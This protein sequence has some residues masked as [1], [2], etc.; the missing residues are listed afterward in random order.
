VDD[1]RGRVP[2]IGPKTLDRIRP[3]LTVTGA[4]RKA[5]LAR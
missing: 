5:A 3:F 4:P 1:L 2:G